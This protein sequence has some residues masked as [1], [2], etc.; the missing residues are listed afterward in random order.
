MHEADHNPDGSVAGGCIVHFGMHKTGSTSIQASLQ[1]GLR[2]PGFRLLDLGRRNA[3]E[4]ISTSFNP[5]AWRNSR[6]RKRGYSRTEVMAR[7]RDFRRRLAAELRRAGDRTAILSAEAVSTLARPVL[8]DLLCCLREYRGSVSAAGYARPPKAYMES[9]YSQHIKSGTRVPEIS[10]LYPRYR[11]AFERIDEVFGRSNVFLWKFDPALLADGC[12]VRDFCRRLGI[13]PP[14]RI[15]RANESLSRPALAIL[16][17]Y[18]EFGPGYGVGI[19]A[20]RENRALTRALRQVRGPRL[21]FAPDFVAPVLEANADDMAW[22][23]ARLGTDL[24]ETTPVTEQDPVLC[25][26][27]LLRV[28]PEALAAFFDAFQALHGVRLPRAMT[29]SPDV[30]PAAVA[31]AVETCRQVFRAAESRYPLWRAVRRSWVSLRRARFGE[32]MPVD[33]GA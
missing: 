1:K 29:A 31:A 6:N 25:N 21:R 12:V 18:R 4:A 24:S 3:S 7:S 16:R 13:R 19:G 23:E 2:D 14:A 33:K 32:N 30:D 8:E 15:I 28:E 22:M 10:S 26:A 20:V 27:D 9:L 17:C 5:D 11:R